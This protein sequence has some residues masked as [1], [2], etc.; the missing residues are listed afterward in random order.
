MTGYDVLEHFLRTVKS[1]AEPIEIR[2]KELLKQLAS[3]LIIGLLF[4]CVISVTWAASYSNV[5]VFEAKS[6]IESDP[7]LVIL[8]VRTQ[9]EYDSGHI[10][11]ARLIPLTELEGR[12]NEL[13]K[14]D[15][16]LVYCGSGTRSAT[17]SQILADNGF[18]HI[19]NMLWGI[20]YW[21][22]QGYT[23][24]VK[25]SSI[26]Q[27]I[28]GASERQSL[29]VSSG[30]YLEH[31]VVNKTISLI[32]ENR[33]S[34]VVDGSLGNYVILVTS[35]K[36]TVNGLVLQNGQNGIMLDNSN[37][38]Y[39]SGN[40][41]RSCFNGLLLSSSC[42]NTV[43]ENVAENN[44]YGIRLSESSHYNIVKR[45]VLSNNDDGFH[46]N[47]DSNEIAE[48]HVFNNLIGI[49]IW[50]SYNVITGNELSN[51]S[52]RVEGPYNDIIY[53]NNFYNVSLEYWNEVDDNSTWNK[54][55]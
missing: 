19:Y 26:Q 9:S 35:D 33:D 14:T 18:L 21:K 28:N 29:Y 55:L 30:T 3:V 22:L 27:A 45:N 5:T 46:L 47:S 16:I 34:T 6:M 8:D 44:N 31:V 12:L 2:R 54:R 7:S 48:N 1:M 49:R 32:G 50:S 42:N 10:R 39:I 36:V 17:A 41:F 23:V 4:L 15:K 53:H 11:N 20:T 40:A 25:Y 43:L 37:D 24:Y 38:S 51:N 13:N 52:I